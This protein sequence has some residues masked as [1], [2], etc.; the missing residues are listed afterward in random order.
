MILYRKIFPLGEGVSFADYIK[1]LEQEII[2]SF[3]FI[4]E[5]ASSTEKYRAKLK[6]IWSFGQSGWRTGFAFGGVLLS[7]CEIL[8]SEG[9]RFFTL[10]A[11][12]TG[13]NL[14]LFLAYLIGASLLFI[15]GFITFISYKTVT[16]QNIAILLLVTAVLSVPSIDLYRYDKKLLKK[17]GAIGM[18]L[19]KEH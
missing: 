19:G 5:E 12:P 1:A 8:H 14:F 7:E 13:I 6:H 18:E 16:F 3:A 4:I 9:E 15:F 2:P 17:I 10:Q 11:S